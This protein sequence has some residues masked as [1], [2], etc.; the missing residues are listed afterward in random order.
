[1]TR[2]E[3][4]ARAAAD[5]TAAF[6]RPPNAQSR[7]APRAMGNPR[8]VGGNRRAGRRRVGGRGGDRTAARPAQRCGSKEQRPRRRP[9]PDGR[10]ACGRTPPGAA[11]DEE[12]QR[13]R[14][15]AVGPT[16]SASGGAP[17]TELPPDLAR[18]R[19]PGAAAEA[20]AAPRRRPSTRTDAAGPDGRRVRGRTPPGPMAVDR[21]DGLRQAPRVTGSR[22]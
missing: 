9:R 21:A 17:A 10:Q 7:W 3:S 4:A 16:G 18:R 22:H 6:R 14:R 8:V 5:A 19:G 12:P 11:G 20:T 1:M 15:G 13:G 2:Q